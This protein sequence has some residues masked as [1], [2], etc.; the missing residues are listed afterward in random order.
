MG[1]ALGMVYSTFIGVLRELTVS[2]LLYKRRGRLRIWF[3][4]SFFLLFL[5]S[6]HM[7]KALYKAYV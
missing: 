1:K 6:K 7:G 5:P 4:L 2:F 3:Y